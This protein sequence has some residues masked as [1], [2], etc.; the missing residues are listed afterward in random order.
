MK[1]SRLILILIIFSLFCCKKSNTGENQTDSRN[2]GKDTLVAVTLSGPT[3]YFLYQGEPMGFDYEN[4]LNFTREQGY[5]LKL[6]IAS[7]MDEMLTLLREKDVDL[8]AYPVPLIEENKKDFIFCGPREVTWQVL[9]QRQD[10]EIISDVTQLI[11]KTIYVEKNSKYFYRI[12]N[13]NDELGRGLDIKTIEKDSLIDEDLLEMVK[14][15][16]ID[17][18]IVDSDVA[19]LNKQYF[20]ELNTDLKIS[21]DQT[22][23][24]AVNKDNQSLKV[25]IDK[26]QNSITETELQKEIYK[27]YFEISKMEELVALVLSNPSPYDKDKISNYDDYFK[28]FGKEYGYDWKLLSSIGYVESRFEPSAQSRFGASGIMQIMPV[29]ARGVGVDESLLFDPQNNIKAGTLVVLKLDNTLKIQIPDSAER[30]KFV[31]AAYNSGLGHIYD[32]MALA[33]KYGLNSKRWQGNVSEMALRK[34]RPEYY[35]DPVVKHGYFRGR[36]TTEF[37]DQVLRIYDQYKQ[38]SIN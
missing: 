2:I 16:E 27:K 15:G 34:S 11:G 18:T 31:L 1:Y 6:K 7:S 23:S 25:Q 4:L 28:S 10:E 3:S 13:L 26:W 36:E 35:N 21:L 20:L 9:V 32:A 17:Y 14:N 12:N 38:L 37:V 30:M 29:A 33:E 22:S 8:I 5:V 24:W 19:A